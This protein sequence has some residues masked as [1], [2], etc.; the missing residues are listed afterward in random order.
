MCFVDIWLLRSVFDVVIVGL[1]VS[2]SLCHRARRRCRH[3]HLSLLFVCVQA[4]YPSKDSEASQ[5]QRL[6]RYETHTTVIA[7][8]IA[9]KLP[10]SLFVAS[11]HQPVVSAV[12]L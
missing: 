2:A 8:N 11:S 7:Q 9:I 3:I 10:A 4:I 12:L 6:N 5:K 1:D